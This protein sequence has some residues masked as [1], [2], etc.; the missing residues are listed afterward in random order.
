MPEIAKIGSLIRIQRKRNDM[1]IERLAKLCNI[2][3]KCIGNIERNKS[4]P[5]ADTFLNICRELHITQMSYF[6]STLQEAYER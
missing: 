6:Y 4:V 2:S 3:S 5:R 1:T